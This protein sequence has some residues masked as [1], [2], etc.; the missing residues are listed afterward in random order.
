MIFEGY[1]DSEGKNVILGRSIF[2]NYEKVCVFD[3]DDT[4]LLHKRVYCEGVANGNGKKILH[5]QAREVVK[6]ALADFDRVVF[7]TIMGSS[8][9]YL[10]GFP[11]GEAHQRIVGGMPCGNVV[12]KDLGILSRNY[13]RNVVAIQDG[14]EEITF[15]PPN[16]VVQVGS[17]DDLVGKY[18]EARA[19]INC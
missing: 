5:G 19:M 14:I 11:F 9:Q 13:M 6:M 2:S 1:V 16:R 4:L 8:L 10:T 18:L 15:E 17:K 7:W 3:V 12:I